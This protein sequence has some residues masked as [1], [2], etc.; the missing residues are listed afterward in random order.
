MNPSVK[1]ALTRYRIAAYVVGT[2]LLV[3]VLVAMPLKYFADN[4]TL[5]E[6]IGPLHGFLYMVYLVVV[7]DLSVRLRW[8]VLKIVGVMLAGTIPFVSF[9]IERRIHRQVVEQ[10]ES[11]NEA[12]ASA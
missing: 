3:L 6:T 2:G 12:H 4:P 8:P 11:R 9:I 7:L 5:T 10:Y 1:S